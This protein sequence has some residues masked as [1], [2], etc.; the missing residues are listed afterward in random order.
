MEVEM[1]I[2]ENFCPVPIGGRVNHEART[3]VVHHYKRLN[4]MPACISHFP[5]L[6]EYSIVHFES[7]T[8]FFCFEQDWLRI[9]VFLLL[10][11]SSR[12][13]NQANMGLQLEWRKERQVRVLEIFKNLQR[14]EIGF[15]FDPY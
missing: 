12:P 8:Q 5:T 1:R 3:E 4:E 7:R 6:P 13:T 2:F 14:L 15:W 9:D 11:E 10:E